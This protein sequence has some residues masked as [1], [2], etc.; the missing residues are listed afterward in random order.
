MERVL[1]L[2]RE[3]HDATTCGGAVVAAEHLILE[4]LSSRVAPV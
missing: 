4:V 1:E 3:T 2:L